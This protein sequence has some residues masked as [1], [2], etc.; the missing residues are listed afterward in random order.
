MTRPLALVCPIAFGLAT[1]LAAQNPPPKDS[2]RDSSRADSPI[3]SAVAP[4]HFLLALS[5]QLH[6]SDS[7]I[8]K[9]QSLEQAQVAAVS[10]ATAAFLRAQADLLDAVRLDDI[11]LRRVALEKRAKIAIDAEV[12]RL[13]AVKE[14][15]AVLSADQRAA[16][17]RLN[18]SPAYSP[19]IDVPEWDGIV[20]IPSGTRLMRVPE[21]PDSNEVRISVTPLY[22]TIYVD[23]VKMGTGRKFLML[24]LGSHELV[25]NAVG[26]QEVR[27]TFEVARGA[28]IVLPRQVLSC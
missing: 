10:K 19:A 12:A 28:P 4:A 11:V 23:N 8:T 21:P 14:S 26:C 15:R 13:Q 20:A 5:D 2:V 3:P 7:Q 22:A 9:L 18:V 27:L 6:L 1:A 17:T 25:V 16:L 24:P